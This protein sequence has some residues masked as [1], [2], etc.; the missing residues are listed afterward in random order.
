VHASA[1]TNVLQHDMFAAFIAVPAGWLAFGVLV[2][3]ELDESFADTYSTVISAQNI[4]PRLDRRVL[5]VLVAGL[6]TVLALVLQISDYFS[7]LYLLGSVFVPMFAVF[8]VDYFVLGRCR[9]WNMSTT[10]P[11][12]WLMVVP[13]LFGFVMYQLVYA[14]AV[15]GWDTMWQHIRDAIGFTWQSWMSASVLSFAV[16]FV[17]TLLVAPFDRRRASG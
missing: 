16:A 3:R 11:S 1:D 5:A 15:L 10:A 14:P 9:R 8:V 6:A 12:R 13:W 17:A 2:L 7:F 4:V